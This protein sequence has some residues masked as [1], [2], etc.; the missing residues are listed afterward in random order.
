M[1]EL[2]AFLKIQRAGVPYEDPAERV[3]Q[4]PYQE[5]L[6]TRPDEELLGAGRALHGVRH[7]VLPQRLPAGQPDPGL[8]RPRLPRPLAGRDPPAAR[9]EQLPRVHRPP[10]PGAVRGRLRAGDPRGRRGHDQADRERD[11]RPRVGQRLGRRPAAAPRD[12]PLGRRR[13]LRARGHGG[14]A[15]AAPLGPQRRPVRARRGRREAC[16]ASACRT[17]RS[18]S[19][20]SSAA[21]SSSWTRASS[22]AAASTWASTSPSTSCAGASTRSCWRSARACRATCRSPAAS[23]TASTSR[24]TT[25]TSATAGSPPRARAATAITAA[26]K[27][28]VVIGGGDTGADCVGNA[29]REGARSITQLELLPEPPAQAARRPH[30]VAA[31][32][33]EVPPLLRHGGGAARSAAASRTSRS[34]RRTSRATTPAASP[35]CTTRRPSP[36]RPSPP[37]R[38]PRA[39]MDAQLVLLAMGFLHPEH[40]GLVDDLGVE[41]DP[42]GNV[43]AGDLRDLGRRRLRGR[44]TPAA[45]SRSSSGRSTRAAS[46]PAWSTATSTSSTAGATTPRRCGR[47]TSMPADEGPEGPPLHVAGRD[48][49]RRPPLARRP[50]GGGARPA[51]KVARNRPRRAIGRHAAHRG[52]PAR[53]RGR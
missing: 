2:G 29:L 3:G 8:E 33:A 21:C 24:W 5:F 47:A 37:W 38:A 11:H 43:K 52:L 13:R 1:G 26:G 14:R 51:P 15:A 50:G 44:A 35:G 6:V 19:A 30:A 41:R 17:S 10:V 4:Q 9:D 45:A 31:V 39:S 20:W 25:S 48:A 46:A 42:R 12:R 16:A 32:A 53:S 49:R 34:S 22:C 7:P 36:R 18:R 23:S 27:D 40:R 28:V